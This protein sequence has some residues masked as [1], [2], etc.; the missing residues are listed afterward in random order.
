[1][2]SKKFILVKLEKIQDKRILFKLSFPKRIKKYFSS[3]WLLSK[4]PGIFL[5]S[6][7]GRTHVWQTL[8]EAIPQKLS[9]NLHNCQEFFEWFKEFHIEKYGL[10][11]E[12]KVETKVLL[13]VLKIRLFN[14]LATLYYSL[15]DTLQQKLRGLLSRP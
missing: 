6:K 1:M 8:Q 10:E 12:K 5:F 14:C 4:N 3:N 9:H 13:E 15:P 2:F 7:E 11:M